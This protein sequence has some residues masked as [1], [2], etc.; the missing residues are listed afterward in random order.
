[1]IKDCD[2]TLYEIVRQKT[3]NMPRDELY[4]ALLD[5][6][7][8]HE[9]V[10]QEV[11]KNHDTYTVDYIIKQSDGAEK[12]YSRIF[13]NKGYEN[14]CRSAREFYYKIT[15]D[16]IYAELRRNPNPYLREDRLSKII[17][18]YLNEETV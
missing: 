5:W 1:M 3:K 4:Y 14:P 10:Q 15:E 2:I 7:D 9:E 12:A 18:K 8:Q 13:T 6:A 16:A 17:C 11:A